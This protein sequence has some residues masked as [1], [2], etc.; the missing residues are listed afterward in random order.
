[1]IKYNKMI[2]RNLP[3]IEFREFKINL[4]TYEKELGFKFP[5]IYKAFLS[6]F[7]PEPVKQYVYLKRTEHEKKFIEDDYRL[8]SS[9]AYSSSGKTTIYEEDDELGFLKFKSIDSLM[10]FCIPEIEGIRDMIFISDHNSSDAL[11]VGIGADNKDKIFLYSEIGDDPIT[12]IAK[13]VFDF[14]FNCQTVEDH[15]DERYY[16]HIR[17]IESSKLYKNWSEEF[18]RVKDFGS[19]SPELETSE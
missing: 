1:M 8:I 12:L 9:V 7:E 4:D 11:L 14:L 3:L 6:N 16:D 17:K 15:L 5:P 10:E 2:K 19:Q 18:W 13:N